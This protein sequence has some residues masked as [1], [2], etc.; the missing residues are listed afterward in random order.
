[1]QEEVNINSLMGTN[2]QQPEGFKAFI[3]APFPPA[4][5]LR[6]DQDLQVKHAEAMITLGRL[7]G[8]SRLL[9][10]KDFF[11]LMFIRKDAASSSQIEG[12][13]ASM[14]ESIE[15]QTM[16]RPTDLPDD[17]SDIL[18][19]IDALNYGIK[20]LSDLPL[21]LRL[22]LEIHKELMT[23]ARSTQHSYPGEFRRTQNWIGGT[24]PVNARFVPPPVHEMNRSLDELEKFIYDKAPVLPLI[25]AGLLH[26]QFET[27][28]P[29]TDGN[30]RTGRMMVT[31]YLTQTGRLGIPVLYLSSYF[32]KHQD[33]YYEVLHSYHSETGSPNEWLNFFLDGVTET[34]ESAIETCRKITELR[35]EDMAKVQ[36]LGKSSAE[37][38]VKMLQHL[39]SLPIVGLAEV[40]KW[41]GYSKQGAYNVIQR[42]I[43]LDIL[44]PRGSKDY[45]QKYEYRR[46]L[47]IFKADEEA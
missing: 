12:T 34:A 18:H 21:S 43:V 1:M 30:G 6:A 8:I 4:A 46:Y 38:T 36:S 35:L 28:H 22:L 14:D 32:K 17:V 39:Y 47:D 9:P 26:S 40:M 33:R 20:R 11:I 41:T 44:S 45:A 29:F 7:D 23:D 42:L 27:I 25:K 24:S 3:P 31:L 13:N 2:V 5:L 16:E 19:Y 37:S 15:A 10:D